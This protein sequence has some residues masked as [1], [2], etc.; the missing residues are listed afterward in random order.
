M[1]GHRFFIPLENWKS[2]ALV[3]DG[4]ESHH[5]V[6]VLRLGEG[7]GVTVFNGR[8]V[9]ATAEITRAAKKRVE[10]RLVESRNSKPLRCTI[11]L[12]QAV[13]KGKNME[14]VLQKATELGAARI[15]PLLTERTVVQLDA[16]DAARKQEKWR[17]VVVEACKQCGQN[18]LPEVRRPVSL[19]EFFAAQDGCDLKLVASLQP[20]ARHLKE[21]LAGYAAAHGGERPC[22]ALILI[23]PEGDFSPEEIALALDQGCQPIT[24]GPIVLR[25]ETAAI[26]CLSVLGHEL[27]G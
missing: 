2:D 18:W 19:R 12:A 26:Y 13:P 27:L 23:G 10:L 11:A 14:L 1:P 8:G 3:L 24:L 5:C 7:D 21:V 25:T 20:D 15:V 16:A 22:S 9:E 17:E 6:D 4:A